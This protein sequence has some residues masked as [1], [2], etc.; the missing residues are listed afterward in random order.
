MRKFHRAISINDINLMVKMYVYVIRIG[1]ES[2]EQKYDK[3]LRMDR[4]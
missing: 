2:M 4:L 3:N 1:S